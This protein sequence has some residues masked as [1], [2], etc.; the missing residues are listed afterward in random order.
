[1]W[2][3]LLGLHCTGWECSQKGERSGPLEIRKPGAGEEGGG[4]VWG[5]TEAF[6]VTAVGRAG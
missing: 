6:M 3:L 1:M 4:Q 5:N 2:V